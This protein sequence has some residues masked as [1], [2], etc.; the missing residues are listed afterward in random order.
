MVIGAELG[1]EDHSSI[2]AT[3]TGRGLEPFDVKPRTRFNLWIESQ[4]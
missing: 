4:K 1:K 3:E 2:L